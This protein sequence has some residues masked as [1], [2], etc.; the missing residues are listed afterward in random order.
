MVSSVKK[1]E[2]E[3]SEVQTPLTA[4]S[5]DLSIC[6][7]HLPMNCVWTNLTTPLS[8]RKMLCTAKCPRRHK[9]CIGSASKPLFGHV[10]CQLGVKCCVIFHRLC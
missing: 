9:Y 6:V 10:Y 7:D 8:F 2:K 3:Q 1:V 4:I 5:T